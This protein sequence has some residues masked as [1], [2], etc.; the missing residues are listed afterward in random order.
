VAD[1]GLPVERYYYWSLMDNFE[2]AE[3]ET[4]A[5]G[6]IDCDFKTQK[7]TVRRSAYF[8]RDI[9]RNGGVTQQMID[10]YLK[11]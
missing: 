5:F 3:G 9:I 11:E 8:Y 4:A 7:R 6:L 2:W 10:T 1:S